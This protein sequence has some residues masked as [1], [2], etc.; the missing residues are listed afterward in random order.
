MCMCVCVYVCVC[1]CVCV[2]IGRGTVTGQGHNQTGG[3]CMHRWDPERTQTGTGRLFHSLCSQVQPGAGEGEPAHSLLGWSQAQS[4]TLTASPFSVIGALEAHRM[5]IFFSMKHI[6]LTH[7]LQ[8]NKFRLFWYFT[9]LES[10]IWWSAK[11][12]DEKY[13]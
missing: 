11:W 2:C 6:T 8:L 13:F 9:A 5:I 7:Y 12:E 10:Y 1:V 4:K 3:G